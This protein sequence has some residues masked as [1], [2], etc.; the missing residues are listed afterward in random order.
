ML[1]KKEAQARYESGRSS[2]RTCRQSRR[3]GQSSTRGSAFFLSYLTRRF[4]S[5]S[6]EHLLH[7]S[8]GLHI[9]ILNVLTA[10]TLTFANSTRAYWT[11][12]SVFFFFLLPRHR[13]E[14]WGVVGGRMGHCGPAQPTPAEAQE[15]FKAFSI[16]SLC[17]SLL[18]FG[19]II[20][21]TQTYRDQVNGITSK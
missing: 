18:L 21:N 9:Q 5:I 4:N 3:P 15:S 8:V 10:L 13:Q 20:H 17:I 2:R 14:A 6:P 19:V 7:V 16:S 12:L 11:S 1:N